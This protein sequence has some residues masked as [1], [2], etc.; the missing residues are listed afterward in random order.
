MPEDG[1]LAAMR[2]YYDLGSEFGRLEEPLG[3]LEFARTREII[4]RHLPPA[5]A[6]VA[7]IGGGPGQYA[8]WLAG[9]GYRV[10]YRDVTPLHVDHV[11]RT[12]GHP[13]IQPAVADA[14]DLDLADGSA[15]AVLLL[16]PLYHLSKR[17][18]RLRALA[19]A[20]R[21]ARPGGSVIAAAISRWSPRI[22]G[23]LR[24]RVYAVVPEAEAVIDEVEGSG[25]LPPLFP[26]SFCGYTHR[27]GQ[28]R[29]EL[30]ASGLTSIEIIGV[31]GPAFMLAD[32][33]ERLSDER[34]RRVILQTARALERVPELAGIS[35]HLLAVGRR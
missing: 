13:N 18:D 27:P 26:G 31:E 23:I 32:L 16:G 17:A 28:L 11:R 20:R 21:V 12:A 30:A 19:E 15:D 1:M 22:D 2:Q 14:R 25:L 5:P 24:G 6:D 4:G 33:A 10:L 35:P 29:A 9:L 7:D 8:T 34:D 3:E